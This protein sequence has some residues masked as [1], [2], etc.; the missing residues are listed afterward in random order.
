MSEWSTETLVYFQSPNC[1]LFDCL[2]SR[3]YRKFYLLDSPNNL[4][5]I[6][7]HINIGIAYG[8][9]MQSCVHSVA[10]NPKHTER[11][12]KQK[13]NEFR[14]ALI[15]DKPFFSSS[16]FA[17]SFPVN[18]PATNQLEMPQWN[19]NWACLI[20]ESPSCSGLE[21][22]AKRIIANGREEHFMC[23]VVVIFHQ[24]LIASAIKRP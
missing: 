20:R 12:C 7:V 6:W 5:R 2:L 13:R 10:T 23:F 21:L 18:S 24:V 15:Y 4:N 16:S 17:C 9:A 11:K 14:N 3:V 1:F 8:M 19:W 22:R